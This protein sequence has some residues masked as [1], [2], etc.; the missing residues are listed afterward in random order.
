MLRQELVDNP[1]TDIDYHQKLLQLQAL[2]DQHHSAAEHTNSIIVTIEILSVAECTY[3]DYTRRTKPA[4]APTTH[5]NSFLCGMRIL[6]ITDTFH[7]NDM[8]PID[9]H[10]RSQ[11]SIDRRMV[12]RLGCRI[13]LGHDL[14][15]DKHRANCASIYL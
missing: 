1:Y 9:T 12:N 4:L 2:M 8:L 3:H 14:K 15:Y 11:T 10:E 7:G 6:N 13:K 5:R